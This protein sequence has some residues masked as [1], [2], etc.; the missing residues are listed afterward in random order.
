MTEKKKDNRGGA[1]K[2]AGRKPVK[3]EQK[4]YYQTISA[5]EK[6]FGTLEAF[7]AHGAK[8]AKAGDYRYWN[9]LME[10]ALGKP[11]ET[12]EHQGQLDIPIINWISKKDK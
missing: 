9:K 4:T 2:G 7:V 11:K 12:V 10:Y 1:R 5:I 8:E 6:V 3:D